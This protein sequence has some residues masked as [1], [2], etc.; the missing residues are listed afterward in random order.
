MLLNA[1]SN[2]KCI[3]YFIL[4]HVNCSYELLTERTKAVHPETRWCLRPSRSA[5]AQITCCSVVIA[6]VV[7]SVEWIRV[8]TTEELRTLTG[9]TM[10]CSVPIETNTGNDRRRSSMRFKDADATCVN[11]IVWSALDAASQ[12]LRSVQAT[13]TRICGIISRLAALRWIGAKGIISFI[14]ESRSFITRYVSVLCG[15]D[16]CHFRV[17]KRTSWSNFRLTS[18]YS[19]YR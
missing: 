16:V 15:F 19:V 4:M 6:S 18:I 8:D 14:L 2:I 10:S 3:N 17:V 7:Y 11:T 9:I 5:Q 13:W 1:L 12:S